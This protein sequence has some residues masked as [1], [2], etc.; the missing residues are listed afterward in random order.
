MIRKLLIPLAGAALMAGCVT[1]APYGYRGDGDYYYGAPSVEYRYRSGYGDPY[2]YGPYRPGLSVYG[3]YG[4]G[5][6]GYPYYRDPYYGYP[7]YGYPYG[8]P[9]H[10][11]PYRG[12]HRPPTPPTPPPP[13]TPV[14]QRP[15]NGG[16]GGPWRHIGDVVRRPGSNP[17]V[18]P[19]PVPSAPRPLPMIRPGADAGGV[20]MPRPM[21][22]IERQ[23]GS[24]SGQLI[25]RAR[26]GMRED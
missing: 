25:R 24:A 8:Y 20:P 14:P 1:T 6:Y 16:D 2:F 26:N 15:R 10:R 22:R 13:G 4:Y 21:P 5:T 9:Y 3:S 19:P 11:D 12:H 17:T 23:D 7:Y 18:A